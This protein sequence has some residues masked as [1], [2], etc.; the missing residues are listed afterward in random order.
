MFAI[1]KPLPR[2]S[3]DSAPFWEA[4]GKGELRMQRCADC[5][6]IRFPPAALCARCLSARC[7]WIA[8]SGRGAVYSWIVVHQSQHPAF[9]VDVPYNVTIVQLDE[10]PRLHTNLIECPN[11]RIHIGM[12]VE[13]VFEKVGDDAALVKFR[14]RRSA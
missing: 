13:A 4:V 7:E 6:H 11:D 10:G 14:P 8:L 2:P 1:E 5:G 9:N 12:P 3:E